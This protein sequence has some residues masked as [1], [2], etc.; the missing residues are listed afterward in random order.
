MKAEIFRHYQWIYETDPQELFEYFDRLLLDADFE[1]INFVEHSFKP[2]GWTC[3]WLL[4]ESHF[5]IH[6]FPEEEVTY[7]E[8]SSCNERKHQYFLDDLEN[9]YFTKKSKK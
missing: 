4:G 2:Q 3:L 6:T 9:A 5:A 1:V 7:I 8:L